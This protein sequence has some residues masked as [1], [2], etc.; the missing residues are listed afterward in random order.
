MLAQVFPPGE[1]LKDELAARKWTREGFAELI[2][3]SVKYVNAIVQG[4]KR[5][6]PAVAD[7]LAEAL[8]TSPELWLNLE[9]TWRDSQ[10]FARP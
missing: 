8:E 2:G 3:E 5:I 4:R 10:P 7:Q 6:T 9:R 1:F